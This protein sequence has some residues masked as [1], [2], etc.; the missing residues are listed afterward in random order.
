MLVGKSHLKSAMKQS[1]MTFG[2]STQA[3]ASSSSVT[4]ESTKLQAAAP[5]SQFK[6]KTATSHKI[7]TDEEFS[8][9]LHKAS[10][11]K[12]KQKAAKHAIP[13]ES[14]DLPDIHSEYSD[15]E[16]ERP[17]LPDWAQS[18]ELRVALEQQS[19][20]NPMDIFGPVPALRMEDIFKEETSRFR[21]RTSSA[22]WAGADRLT[23]E[24]EE[25]YARR[26]GFK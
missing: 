19:K 20:Y 12:S 13:S 10:H 25:N 5:A 17:G 6:M 18:P 22:N 8:K 24:E 21:A 3:M 2:S 7:M 14:I 11:T 1:T 15:S 4:V 26:M 16:D 23:V 9:P